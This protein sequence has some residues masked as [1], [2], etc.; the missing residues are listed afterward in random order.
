MR[1]SAA[2]SA[3]LFFLPKKKKQYEGEGP[4]VIMNKLKREGERVTVERRKGRGR[5]DGWRMDGLMED[6]GWMRDEG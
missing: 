1:I 3:L 2:K 4:E 6:G 5:M